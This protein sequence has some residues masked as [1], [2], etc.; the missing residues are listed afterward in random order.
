MKVAVAVSAQS[1]EIN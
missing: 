1:C